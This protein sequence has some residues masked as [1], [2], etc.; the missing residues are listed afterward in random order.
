MVTPAGGTS[1]VRR[2]G[3]ACGDV[4]DGPGIIQGTDET[5]HAGQS[6][7][8]I[9]DFAD[10]R[11]GRAQDADQGEDRE[12]EDTDREG[13]LD[14]RKATAAGEAGEVTGLLIEGG[15]GGG[16]ELVGVGGVGNAAIRSHGD[17]G[18]LVDVIAIDGDLATG[19]HARGADSQ[20]QD[21]FA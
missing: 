8:G 6:A 3:L 14:E 15:R 16:I 10:L 21:D 20:H 17:R 19:L 11:K 1:G 13:D 5:R 7:V 9:H 18:E 12:P 4:G 2:R